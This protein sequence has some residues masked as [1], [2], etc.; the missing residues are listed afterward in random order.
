M[1]YGCDIAL[2]DE[3]NAHGRRFKFIID[4]AAAAS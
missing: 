3:T 1:R 4:L 2:D